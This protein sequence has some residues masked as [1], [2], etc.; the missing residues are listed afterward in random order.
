MVDR[1]NVLIHRLLLN[2]YPCGCQDYET[3]ALGEDM[4][5]M[6]GIGDALE[7]GGDVQ[8]TEELA[9]LAPCGEVFLEDFG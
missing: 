6:D 1:P 3:D 7:I 2:G 4:E 9:P 5:E 8:P